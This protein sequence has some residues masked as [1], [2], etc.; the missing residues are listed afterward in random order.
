MEVS[1]MAD[2]YHQVGVKADIEQVY[3]ALTTLQGLGGWWTKVTGDT[4]EGGRLSFHFDDIDIEMTIIQLLPTKV[5][6]Q[7]SEKEGEWKDT[8]ISFELEQSEDQ[9]FVNFS[10][11]GWAQQ[12]SLC[13]HC[14][15]K[16]AVFM[17]SLKGYLEK[18]KGQPFP[19]DVHV[20]HTDI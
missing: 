16:W 11:T 10:H 12:T 5:V 8:T 6:W 9:V 15:T 19:D 4:A 14:S 18:G 7:C 1:I 20:N 13:A 17:M 2:I 3:R